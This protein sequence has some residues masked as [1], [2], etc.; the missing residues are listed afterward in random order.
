MDLGRS[1]A[2]VGAVRP[3]LNRTRMRACYAP[4]EDEA[5]GG[6]VE[7]GLDAASGGRETVEERAY[8]VLAAARETFPPGV[9]Q[10]FGGVH[11]SF[12]VRLAPSAGPA[13][14][15]EL[16][17]EGGGWS[18]EAVT[19]VGYRGALP[20]VRVTVEGLAAEGT[21]VIGRRTPAGKAEPDRYWPPPV[22]EIEETFVALGA[23]IEDGWLR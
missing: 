20:A 11:E 19:G 12:A 7:T 5:Q 1:V 14:R 2:L 15:I 17:A 3:F 22:V 6:C 13:H 16:C 21:L 10:G 4:L 8:P 23:A 9:L 18:I